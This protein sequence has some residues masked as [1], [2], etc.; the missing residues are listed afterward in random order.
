MSSHASSAVAQHQ[1]METIP[2]LEQQQ[3]QQTNSNHQQQAHQQQ[4]H[5]QQHHQ[6]QHHQQAQVQQAMMAALMA[7]GFNVN[8]NSA[9]AAAQVQAQVQAQAQ[10]ASQMAMQNMQLPVGGQSVPVQGVSTSSMQQSTG[11]GGGAPVNPFA[12]V[13]N[14]NYISAPQPAPVSNASI[15]Q[16][17]HHHQGQEQVT[18]VSAPAGAG[19]SQTGQVVVQQQQ[20]QNCAVPANVPSQ[21][22]NVNVNNNA[23]AAA[24]AQ[25]VAAHSAAAAQQQASANTNTRNNIVQHAGGVPSV[26][27]VNIKNWKL[28]QLEAHAQLLRDTNQTIPQAVALLLADAR[29]K[30]EKR[31]AKRVANR[32]SACT[33]RARKKALVEEMTKVNAIL[34][35]QAMILALL[36]DLVIAIQADGE[37]TFCSEQVE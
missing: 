23:M 28:S 18:T 24:A 11:G 34:K 9:Q 8:V 7:S 26:V 3:A 30:E 2:Q 36:P 14:V 37:I 25:V 15:Q 1:I 19:S 29:R 17:Q 27:G 16:Q 12:I 21:P 13:N 10:A 31:T 32:K 4:H 5:Q 33:S 20:H 6:Q 22:F 35:R